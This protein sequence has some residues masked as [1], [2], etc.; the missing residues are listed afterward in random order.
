MEGA[1]AGG[2]GKDGMPKEERGVRLEKRGLTD[3]G[4]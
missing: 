3:R 1:E 2:G 4:L